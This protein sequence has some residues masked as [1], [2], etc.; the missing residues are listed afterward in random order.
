MVP[1]QKEATTL[2]A[3]LPVA[4]SGQNSATRCP[5]HIPDKPPQSQSFLL[6][7]KF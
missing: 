3:T 4:H 1:N 6:S 7:V 2:R 5:L